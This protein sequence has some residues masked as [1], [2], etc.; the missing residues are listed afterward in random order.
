MDFKQIKAILNS[1]ADFAPSN[2]DA[3]AEETS[4][5]QNSG[6]PQLCMAGL[7]QEACRP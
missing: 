3:D 5:G 2:N 4:S 6:P 7:G 1:E